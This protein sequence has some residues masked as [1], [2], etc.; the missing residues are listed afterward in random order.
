MPDLPA[1]CIA[2]VER[3]LPGESTESRLAQAQRL[4][5]LLERRDG[6]WNGVPDQRLAVVQAHHLH[7]KHPLDPDAPTRA[8][9]RAAVV[10][11]I[12]R[13]GR[14][15]IPYVLT[16]PG[17]GDQLVSDP[18]SVARTAYEEFCA[19]AQE[20]GV[21]LLVELLS[22]MRCAALSKATDLARWLRELD[23]GSTLK[24][25]MDIGHLMD[26][27]C[28]P[29]N[30]LR[31]W[32]LPVGLLQLRGPGGAFPPHPLPIRTLLSEARPDIVS[33]EHHE[34]APIDQIE[35]LLVRVRR[36]RER[37]LAERETE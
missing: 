24:A 7:A 3:S 35:H 26:A 11:T 23:A 20:C 27:G 32:P 1:M 5:L 18:E 13:A 28:D 15:G 6:D 8:A 14:A 30:V 10:R 34:P 37:V 2:Y 36:A 12:Q 29:V 19:V 33:V 16:V 25:A 22:P 4:D 21:T 9:A 17:F 31:D